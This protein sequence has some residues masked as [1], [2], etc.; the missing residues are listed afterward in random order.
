MR[1]A[2]L[3]IVRALP[4]FNDMRETL[5]SALMGAAFLQT[6]PPRVLL[7]REGELPD[8]LHVIAEGA[9]ELFSAHGDR[10]TTIDIVV[11]TTTFILAAVIRDEVYLNRSEEHT[12][13]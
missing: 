2:D 1:A 4:L 7:I 3:Q 10:E 5:F 12:S 6:F 11:P 8:F 9:V 13:E